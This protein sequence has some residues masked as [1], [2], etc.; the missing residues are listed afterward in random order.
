MADGPWN[1][2]WNRFLKA[3]YNCDTNAESNSSGLECPPESSMTK[4]EF[5]EE[6]DINNIA[7][8]FGLT[9]HM[10]LNWRQPMYGSNGNAV[11]NSDNNILYRSGISVPVKSFFNGYFD[12]F[13]L[14]NNTDDLNIGNQNSIQIHPFLS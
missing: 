13:H 7:K 4:Q 8:N 14:Y 12:S 6:C 2:P 3:P 10:P 11:T 1:N 5:K 9:G